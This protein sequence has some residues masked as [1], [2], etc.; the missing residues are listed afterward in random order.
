[1][2]NKQREVIYAQ[3]RQ[4]LM[5]EDLKSSI[6]DMLK[7]VIFDAVDNFTVGSQYP[8]EW[9]ITG[10]LEYLHNAFL[11]KRTLKVSDIS[12][13]EK[14]ERKEAILDKS[15]ELY[16]A[17]EAEI[18]PENMRELERVILLR[19]VD[20]KWMDHLDAMDQLRDGISLRAFGQ[21]DPV[22]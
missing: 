3:R 4:V 18:G 19:V 2:M 14:E 6:I 20:S 21:Q 1:V 16:E 10:L 11:P 5:E 8:E 17:K 12:G 7:D 13:L 22:Q 15:L 9:D